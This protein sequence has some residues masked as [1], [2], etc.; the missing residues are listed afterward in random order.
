M[1]WYK[2]TLK[3]TSRPLKELIEVPPVGLIPNGDS[4]TVDIPKELAE[5]YNTSRWVRADP[6]KPPVE[7]VVEETVAEGGEDK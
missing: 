5:Q 1:P 4:I 6:A 3:Q 2:V 7:V